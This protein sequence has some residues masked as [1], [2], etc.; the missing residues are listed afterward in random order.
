MTKASFT[1][2]L[3]AVSRNGWGEG[4]RTTEDFKIAQDHDEECVGIGRPNEGVLP[5]RARA[6]AG[7]RRTRSADFPNW[8]SHL[9]DEKGDSERRDACRVATAERN[10]RK[11]C[12]QTHPDLF[13]RGMLPCPWGYGNRPESMGSKVR[14]PCYI[15]ITGGVGRSDHHRIMRQRCN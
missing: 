1:A 4:A 14:Q 8:G 11:G 5:V 7:R 9:L 10:A 6:G 3:V 2:C 13:L 15:R 12:S